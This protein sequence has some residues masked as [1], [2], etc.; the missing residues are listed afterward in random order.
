MADLICLS[1]TLLFFLASIGFVLGVQYL[2][3]EE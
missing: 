1:I 2:L 3:G